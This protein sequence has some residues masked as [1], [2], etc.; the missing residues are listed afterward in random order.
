MKLCRISVLA[1]VLS[2]SAVL[3]TGCAGGGNP[4]IPR[5]TKSAEELRQLEQTQCE[6]RETSYRN[7]T[8][9]H[10]L[11]SAAACALVNGYSF[12]ETEATEYD[13]ETECLTAFC[14]VTGLDSQTVKDAAAAVLEE[15]KLEA[16]PLSVLLRDGNIT[17]ALI[18]RALTANGTFGRI[19]ALLDRASE[20]MK[21]VTFGCPGYSALR[22]Y[23][24]GMAEYVLYCE[25]P[26]G[27]YRELGAT[28]K[29]YEASLIDPRDQ[30][31]Q[32]AK[33]SATA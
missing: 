14:M 15:R 24:Y 16:Q 25:F 31:E 5:E 12:S 28:V 20:T 8:E 11:C 10:G 32:L 17:V 13:D 4:S 30:L 29:A 9:A 3:L 19:D 26:S 22:S 18:C 27:S 1:A 6:A 2:L 21:T 7:L 33:E 23:Y